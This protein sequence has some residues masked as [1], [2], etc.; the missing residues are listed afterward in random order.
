MIFAMF[1]STSLNKENGRGGFAFT[2]P[3]S[4]ERLAI[5]YMAT[6]AAAILI[7]YLYTIAVILLCFAALGITGKIVVDSSWLPVTA[8]G[9]GATFMWY[10]LLQAITGS[11]GWPGGLF[12]GL[13]WPVFS[14]AAALYQ[15]DFFGPIFHAAIA[16]VDFFNPFAYFGISSSN[17]SVSSLSLFG[18]S[19]VACIAITWSVA[20][21]ACAVAIFEWK[22]VEV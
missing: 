16:V 6:D 4:R 8:A 14:L 22:R 9:L 21:V 15:V 5:G 10:G 13:S 7:A 11:L 20:F 19:T 12:A 17:D 3:I 18:F 2:K 1:V